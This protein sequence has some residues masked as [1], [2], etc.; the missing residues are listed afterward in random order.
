MKY[1][2]SAEIRSNPA[3]LWKDDEDN[4]TIITVN[5]KPKIITLAINGDPQEMLSLI[6]RI[7]AER[8]VE[9]MW[10]TSK[11]TGRSSM[12]MDEIENEIESARFSQ[13]I[14]KEVMRRFSLL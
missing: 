4:E 6:R 2:S 1:I 8:A 12:T 3:I 11:K 5:G 14:Q 10:M 9:H 13:S 7:R